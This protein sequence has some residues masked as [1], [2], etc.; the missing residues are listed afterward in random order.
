[1]NVSTRQLRD[2]SFPGAVADAVR[3]HAL[4]PGL[5]TLEIT[6]S[7]LPDDSDRIITLLNNLKHVGVRVAVDDFGTGYSAL[8]RLQVYPVDVLKID[9]SFITGIESDAGKAQLVRGI[10]N[11][12]DSL[13]ISVVAEGIE[14]R[15]QVDQLRRMRSPLG[16]G[17]LFSKPVSPAAIEDLLRSGRPLISDPGPVGRALVGSG[18]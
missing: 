3:E 9:R 8:S 13:H 14:R 18:S 6:E 5:L 11:L 4:E 16:Q 2:P 1:M 7:L 12:A 17:F 15:G 10:V